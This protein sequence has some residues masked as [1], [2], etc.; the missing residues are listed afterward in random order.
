[1]SELIEQFTLRYDM[2]IH[3]D[4]AYI[5][6]NSLGYGKD[7]TIMHLESYWLYSYKRIY[8]E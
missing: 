4:K 3:E 7:G 1:M 2:F 6:I 8:N 5:G